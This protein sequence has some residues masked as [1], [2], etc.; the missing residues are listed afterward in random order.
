MKLLLACEEST[1]VRE[2]F[3]KKGVDAYSCDLQESRLGADDP[4]HIQGDVLPVLKQ[5][6]DMVISFPTC[7]YLT[8]TGNK[9]FYHPDDSD[10]P[11]SERRP[12]PRFPDRWQQQAEGAEFFMNF[13]DCAPLW[14]IENPVGCMSRL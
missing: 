9:W 1:T 5:G 6:W 8:V 13:V 14:V 3:R 7:T 4:Y 2:A 10:M 12:H 11:T